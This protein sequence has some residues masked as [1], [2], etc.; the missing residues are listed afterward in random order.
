MDHG[1]EK[2]STFTI[3]T[4]NQHL[5]DDDDDVEK[6]TRISHPVLQPHHHPH[7]WPNLEN[8]PILWYKLWPFL[9]RGPAING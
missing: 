8:W 1:L 6:P 7:L 9:N 3:F 4:A 2:Y 5:D